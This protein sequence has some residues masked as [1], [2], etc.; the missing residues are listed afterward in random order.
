VVLLSLAVLFAL[1]QLSFL[2]AV[3]H[4]YIANVVAIIAAGPVFVAVGAGLFLGERTSLRVW[5][6]IGLTLVGI[7]LIVAP[8]LGSLNIKGDLFALLAIT[9]FST[10]LLLLRTQ[11]E[12]SRYLIL[13]ASAAL[14]LLCG[15]F[16]VD[17]A[18]QPTSAWLCAGLG[19]VVLR[20]ST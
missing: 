3:Q 19:V 5:Q 6:A 17:V 4:T 7:G 9:G 12:M 14:I 20:G 1:T 2:E 11:P 10:S 15:V 13:S 8:S 18:A 16:W